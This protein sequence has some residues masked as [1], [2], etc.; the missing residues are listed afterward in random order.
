MTARTLGRLGG[1]EYNEG[2]LAPMAQP[3][4]ASAF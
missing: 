2:V 3:D 4:S 1:I